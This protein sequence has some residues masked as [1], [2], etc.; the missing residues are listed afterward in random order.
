[1]TFSLFQIVIAIVL[2]AIAIVL[3]WGYLRYKAAGADRRLQAMLEKAGVDPAVAR[4]GDNESIMRDVRKRCRRCQTE[5]VC[6][7]W[8][9]G[10]V[11][12]DNEFCPNAGVF[13]VLA[14]SSK[15][16]PT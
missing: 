11:E 6:E 5:D 14:G 2:A 15:S 8:L 10:A 7:R 3:A 1:M 16:R 4:S 9:A 12:G 13:D